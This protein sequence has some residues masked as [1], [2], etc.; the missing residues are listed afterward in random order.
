MGFQKRQTLPDQ[1]GLREEV[2]EHGNPDKQM[3]FQAENQLEE[4]TKSKRM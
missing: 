4:G 1:G 2:T 3:K